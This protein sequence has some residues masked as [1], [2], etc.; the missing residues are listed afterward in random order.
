MVATPPAAPTCSS[1]NAEIPPVI[2]SGLVGEAS[3]GEKMSI[4]GPTQSRMSL[5][6]LEY[7]KKKKNGTNTLLA[8]RWDT[9][10]KKCNICLI[11][12]YASISA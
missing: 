6:T 9:T 8:E 1:Q 3:R 10:W 4:M 7:T 2:D 5:S 12:P 11:W